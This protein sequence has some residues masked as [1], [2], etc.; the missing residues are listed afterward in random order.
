MQPGTCEKMSGPELTS[1]VLAVAKK[2]GFS[3]TKDN[4][5]GSATLAQITAAVDG[6]NQIVTAGTFTVTLTAG[7][8]AQEVTVP[9]TGVVKTKEVTEAVSTTVEPVVKV[10]K[11]AA[12]H[13][14]PL[15][16]LAV[17]AA[18]LVSACLLG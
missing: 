18:A 9:V 16:G 2:T 7:G 11:A 6:T 15:F 5:K 12:G 1:N 13:P 3:A 8:E 17:A 14:A 10:P 4:F